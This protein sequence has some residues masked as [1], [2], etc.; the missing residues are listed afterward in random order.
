VSGDWQQTL[1]WLYA[2]EARL[3]MDFRLERLAPVLAALGAPERRLPV[4]HIA[5]TNGKGS[6]AAMLESVWR[7]AGYRTGLYTSPHLLSFCERIRLDG[8]SID[9]SA[10]LAAVSRVREAMAET[11]TEL[12]FFEIATLAA[13][14]AMDEAAVE[15][16]VL[17]AGLGGRLDAT[18]VAACKLAAVVTSVARD[19]TA[20]LGETPEEIAREKAGIAAAGRPFLAGGV[21]AEVAAVLEAEGE[22]R[23]ALPLQRL[24]RDFDDCGLP[25]LALAG[26]HQRGNAALARATVRSLA[27]VLPVGDAQLEAGLAAARWPGRF[28][29]FAGRPGVILDGAHNPEAVA[30]LVRTLGETE[31]ARPVVA[32]F[33][34][35]ADKEWR[36]MLDRLLPETAAI[37]LVPLAMERALDPALAEDYI[38]G[39]VPVHR[40]AGAEEAVEL[41]RTL[42]GTE[43]T[44]LV[45]GSIFLVAEVYA[46]VGGAARLFMEADIAA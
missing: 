11:G 25:P 33:A 7:R 2:R 46:A 22:R 24:G 43:G 38:A 16:A 15:V 6:V 39:R 44:V 40:A 1:D 41:A 5:G 18:N 13:F 35:M 28:E 14:V 20:Y 23:G 37:V 9:E 8:R 29:R 17:E 34:V 26:S 42:A 4:V 32:V 36:P 45:T 21:S 10:A 19:H 12:T 31:V 27:A 3:G 30:T